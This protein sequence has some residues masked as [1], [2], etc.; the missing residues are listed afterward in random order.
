MSDTPETNEA[1][2]G[3][4]R[5]S[6]YFARRLELQRNIAIAERDELKHLVAAIAERIGAGGNKEWEE[7]I[8]RRVKEICE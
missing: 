1:Q 4:G 8:N 6:V 3:T 2:F 7:S 5:V